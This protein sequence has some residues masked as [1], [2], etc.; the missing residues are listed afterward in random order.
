[1]E[2]TTS[3]IKLLKTC[4]SII[5]DPCHRMGIRGE[6]DGFRRKKIGIQ[7]QNSDEMILECT[8]SFSQTLVSAW[9]WSPATTSLSLQI[10]KD[11]NN[12]G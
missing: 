7:V 2:A 8:S 3:N 9:S 6:E 1:M 12:E 4:R 11:A 10:Q 5:L